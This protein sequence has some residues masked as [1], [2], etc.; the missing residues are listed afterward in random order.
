MKSAV[1]TTEAL[2]ATFAFGVSS[3]AAAPAPGT[4]LTS[5]AAHDGLSVPS[6]LTHAITK[7]L[8]LA[9]QDAAAA[10]GPS[11]A[12]QQELQASGGMPLDLFGYT[13]S[14]TADGHTALVGAP[15][16]TVGAAY[17]FVQRGGKWTEQQELD[18]PAGSAQ[19]S[20]GWSVTL[21]GDGAAALVGAYS[22]NNLTGIVYSYVLK[23]GSY[24]LDG[25]ITPPDGA[26]GDAFGASV[27]LSGL[28]NVAL[29]GAPDHNGFQGAAYLFVRGARSW[30]QQHEYQDPVAAGEAYGYSVSEAPDGLAGVVGAPFANGAV[31][32]AYAFLEPGSTQQTL[33]G[34][35]ATPPTSLFGLSVS[36]DALADRILVGSPSANLGDGAAFVFDKGRNGWA[37][38]QELD[39]SNPSGADLFGYSVALDYLGDFALIGAPERNG[40]AGSAFTFAGH[41][42]LAQQRELTEPT[43]VQG[44][45]YGDSVAVSALGS[46]LLIGAPYRDN[47]QGA[48]WAADN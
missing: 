17:V 18:S 44:D 42:K 19:D 2:A 16:R 12:Q 11:P 14:L 7:K 31:G 37:Q 9:P 5:V 21:A 38:S 34:T 8:G 36:I 35:A 39:E 1:A 29:I 20:Y 48:A 30:T 46:E 13:V 10:A 33:V 43:A 45:E 15:G 26:P 24:V 6:A 28:G 22:G 40:T 27:S 25:Q 47:A 41:G 23:G 3:A 4:P 32:A